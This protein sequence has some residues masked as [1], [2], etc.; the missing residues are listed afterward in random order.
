MYLTMRAA[1]I[2]NVIAAASN[3]VITLV[4]LLIAPL[5]LAAVIV[6]TALVTISTFLVCTGGDWV[7]RWLLPASRGSRFRNGDRKV[8]LTDSVADLERYDDD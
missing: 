5:G 1:F 7:V 3:G 8:I 4:L 6:N 2:R